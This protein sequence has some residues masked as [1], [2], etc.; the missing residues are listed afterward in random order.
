MAVFA[1]IAAQSDNSSSS[2]VTIKI[3]E[4]SLEPKESFKEWQKWEEDSKASEFPSRGLWLL[5]VV[6]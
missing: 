4:I 1:S 5:S 2:G 6:T 3:Y